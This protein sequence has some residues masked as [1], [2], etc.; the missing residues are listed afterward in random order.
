MRSASSSTSPTSLRGVPPHLLVGVV[1]SSLV[2]HLLVEDWAEVLGALHVDSLGTLQLIA[3][4]VHP[5]TQDRDLQRQSLQ[6][7]IQGGHTESL[8]QWIIVRLIIRVQWSRHQELSEVP[9]SLFY[10][11]LE[12]LILLYHHL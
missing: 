9:H 7:V 4:N 11:I 1:T 8:Q 6:W 10:L 5:I 12:L 3:H 2:H